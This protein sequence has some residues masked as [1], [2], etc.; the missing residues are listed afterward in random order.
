MSHVRASIAI[1]GVTII[2]AE[3]L[4]YDRARW[5]SFID[6][7]KHVHAVEGDYPRPGAQIK[8]ESFPGGRG[9]VLEK[10]VSYEPCD[11]QQLDVQDGQIRGRQQVSFATI[12]GEQGVLVSLELEY[13][14]SER[15]IFTPLVD[16]V[17]VRRAQSESLRRTLLRFARELEAEPVE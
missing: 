1:P 16:I 7:L 4:W 15:S 5:P 9:R 12:D 13:V 2:E 6:G 17:F 10:V 3:A 14:I 8:W 11:G